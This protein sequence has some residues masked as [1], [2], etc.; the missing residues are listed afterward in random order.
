[1]IIDMSTNSKER[2]RNVQVLGWSGPRINLAPT[3][4]KE[5]RLSMQAVMHIVA[6]SFSGRLAYWLSLMYLS[7]ERRG[8]KPNTKLMV[9]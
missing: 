9:P 7:S 3:M 4:G 1:M 6:T 8:V 5:M 2:V